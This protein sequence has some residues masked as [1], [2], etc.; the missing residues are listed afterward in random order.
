MKHRRNS[1]FISKIKSVRRIVETISC[2]LNEKLNLSKV[3]ARDAS[4]LMS[5][6]SRKVLIHT[7]GVLLNKQLNRSIIKFDGLLTI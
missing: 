6:F 2:Q 1:I 5:R 4:H 3:W 7:I